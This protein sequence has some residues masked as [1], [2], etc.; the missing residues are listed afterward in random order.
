VAPRP[1]CCI[2]VINEHIWFSSVYPS[3]PISSQIG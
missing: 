3:K 1:Y 2:K